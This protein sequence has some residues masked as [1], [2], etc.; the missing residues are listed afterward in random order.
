MSVIFF[1]YYPNAKC[2]DSFDRECPFP[3]ATGV[4]F[5]SGGSFF[6]SGLNEGRRLHIAAISNAAFP[7]LK[8]W[9][10]KSFG[11]SEPTVSGYVPGTFYKR[12]W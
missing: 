8:D 2:G 5:E 1:R 9:V 11:D 10:I 7:T 6:A 4:A 3:H 12:I